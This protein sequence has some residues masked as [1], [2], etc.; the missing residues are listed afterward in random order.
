MDPD[1]TAL[2]GADLTGSALFAE[3]IFK[4]SADKA[5]DFCCDWPFQG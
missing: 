5:N 4:I 2:T 3:Y 1:Q